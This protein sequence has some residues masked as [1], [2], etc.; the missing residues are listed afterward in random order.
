MKKHNR[1]I[2]LARNKP[3]PQKFKVTRVP[4]WLC[5]HTYAF[6]RYYGPEKDIREN[7]FWTISDSCA[8]CVIDIWQPL[9]LV[10]GLV[11]IGNKEG[12]EENTPKKNK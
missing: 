5:K 3:N 9:I 8:L 4:I 6:S 12:E 1:S 7:Y 11:A 10:E 2:L